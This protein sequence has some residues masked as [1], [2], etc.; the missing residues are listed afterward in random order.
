[1]YVEGA[2]QCPFSI[3]QRSSFGSSALEDLVSHLSTLRP[4]P[5]TVIRFVVKRL[6]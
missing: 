6:G 3:I 5:R 1:M 2:N 4:L